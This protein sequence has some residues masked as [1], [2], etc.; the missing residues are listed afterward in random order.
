MCCQV[1]FSQLVSRTVSTPALRDFLDVLCK[2]TS[3]AAAS[4]LPAA[5]VVRA[6]AEMYQSGV[7]KV[8][9]FYSL[10]CD[11]WRLFYA[12]FSYLLRDVKH[13]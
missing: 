1:M 3:G 4:A 10:G 5:Y 6:F 2:G 11:C 9:C 7:C 12:F 8:D 13:D